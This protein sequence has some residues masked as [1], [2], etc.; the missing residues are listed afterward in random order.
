MYADFERFSLRIKKD[1][2]LYASHPG[3]CDQEVA[4]L[5]QHPYIKK[6]LDK[7]A[8]EILRAELGE[9]GAWDDSE[10]S[11]HDQNRERIVW[12]AC[13]DIAENVRS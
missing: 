7:I 11:D 13:G 4:W 5:T 9:Y 12:I 1:D 10:L 8:P 6:Q 3:P 2:A